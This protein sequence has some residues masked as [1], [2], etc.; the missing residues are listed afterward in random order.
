MS[1]PKF[2]TGNVE[3]IKSFL[4]EFDVRII[5]TSLERVL[6]SGDHVF[7]GTVETLEMLRS[8]GKRLIFVTNNS[9]KSRADYKKKLDSMSIACTIGEIYTSSS[10]SAL[11]ISTLL[12]LPPTRRTV[13]ILGESGIES[14]LRAHN[15][16]STCGTDP[17]FRRDITPADY[18]AISRLDPTLLDNS[19]G[20][21]LA[22]LDFHPSYLKYALAYHH[23]ASRGAHFLA[24]NTDATLPSAGALFP[25]AGSMIAPLSNMLASKK[26][27]GPLAMGKP[28]QTFLEAVEKGVGWEGRE[29]V[30]MVGDR[31]DTD[32]RFGV[33]GGLG[34]TL[35]VLTGVS[36]REEM[37]GLND[38]G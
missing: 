17:T 4:D 8:A 38:G 24:T 28:S 25:G 13:F 32:I 23:I 11:Y 3:A 22:G 19:V 5:N 35:G 7:D 14:E 12:P 37:R 31:V 1:G 30:C 26:I 2:L 16:P 33:E 21:V 34:G 9:T 20:C 36:S 10:A 27:G 6:W 29:K 18:S 15:I